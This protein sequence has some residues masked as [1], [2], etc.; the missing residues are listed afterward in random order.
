MPDLDP[1]TLANES[2]PSIP[3]IPD[4]PRSLLP[5]ERTI[6]GLPLF[7]LDGRRD[8]NNTVAWWPFDIVNSANLEHNCNPKREKDA[9]LE[10][11]SGLR[12]RRLGLNNLQD[13]GADD[14]FRLLDANG[15]RLIMIEDHHPGGC[16]WLR[17][18]PSSDREGRLLGAMEDP[19]EVPDVVA[20][21]S[22]SLDRRRNISIPPPPPPRPSETFARPNSNDASSEPQLASLE[23][24]L[25]LVARIMSKARILPRSP[26][27][28]SIRA[29][30]ILRNAFRDVLITLARMPRPPSESTVELV[31]LT[32]LILADALMALDDHHGILRSNTRLPYL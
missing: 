10:H 17:F 28:R 13:E 11:I 19:L 27:P 14:D 23:H 21:L 8:M 18:H 25:S 30:A 24:L 29:H 3:R 9:M 15:V 31:D 22:A 16:Y 6:F 4:Y 12:R 7:H 1:I 5:R 26:G 20:A 2:L 32:S